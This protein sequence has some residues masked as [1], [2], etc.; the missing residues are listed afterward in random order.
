[1]SSAVVLQMQ[2][3]NI[4]LPFEFTR[5]T[6]ST[7]HAPQP[8]HSLEDTG[9]NL[10]NQL[11]TQGPG[12]NIAADV[13]FLGPRVIDLRRFRKSTLLNGNEKLCGDRASELTLRLALDTSR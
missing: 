3:P 2:R 11:R 10:G 12:Q 4:G 5:L 6:G 7:G 8:E 9:D 13:G 1:M